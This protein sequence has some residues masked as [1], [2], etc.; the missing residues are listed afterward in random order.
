MCIRDSDPTVAVNLTGLLP[1]IKPFNE[2]TGIDQTPVVASDVTVF[3]T[4]VD[5]PMNTLT[6]APGVVE[7]DMEVVVG[8]MTG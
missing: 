1:L 7:P 6:V 5:D 3:T 2:L 4:A 8:L